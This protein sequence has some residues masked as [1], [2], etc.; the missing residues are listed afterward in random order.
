MESSATNQHDV[1]LAQM[2][3]S[4]DWK[5]MIEVLGYVATATLPVVVGIFASPSQELTHTTPDCRGRVDFLNTLPLQSTKKEPHE[6]QPR[7]ILSR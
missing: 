2:A 7:R 1:Q 6:N 5:G 3:Q 4:I